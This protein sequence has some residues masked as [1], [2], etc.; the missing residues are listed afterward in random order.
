MPFLLFNE[1][2]RRRGRPV[3]SRGADRPLS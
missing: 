2:L 3:A 1:R